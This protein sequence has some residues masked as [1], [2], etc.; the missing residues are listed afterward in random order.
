MAAYLNTPVEVL[1]GIGWWITSST[2]CHGTPSSRSTA[3]EPAATFQARNSASP[4]AQYAARRHAGSLCAMAKATDASTSRWPSSVRHIERMTRRCGDSGRLAVSLWLMNTFN[5][6]QPASVLGDQPTSP[7]L[8]LTAYVE[9][10]AHGSRG[11]S[12]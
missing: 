12:L 3:V 5:R 9:R 2:A 10:G 4:Q 11:D 8:S 6:Q 7:S 1:A